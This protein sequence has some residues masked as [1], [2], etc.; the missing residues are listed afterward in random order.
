M[1]IWMPFSTSPTRTLSLALCFSLNVSRSLS[2]AL[3]PCART[4]SLYLFLSFFTFNYVV[5]LYDSGKSSNSKL[6]FINTIQN[7]SLFSLCWRYF[8]RCVFKGFLQ[9]RWE[10]VL[11]MSK[12][13]IV[14]EIFHIQ[15]IY[16]GVFV[17]KSYPFRRLGMKNGQNMQES[18]KI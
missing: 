5:F 9:L 12:K 17:I 10:C 4:P 16:F 13:R 7:I 8:V 1:L 3:Y 11:C 18:I 14:P 15:C 2:F 6:L